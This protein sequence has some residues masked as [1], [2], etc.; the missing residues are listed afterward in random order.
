MTTLL[1]LL[2]KSSNLLKE[3]NIPFALSGGILADYY[4]KDPRATDD[5]DLLVAMSEQE[6]AIGESILKALGFTPTIATEAM[7]RGDTRFKRKTKKSKP[8]IISGRK[9]GTPYGLDFL[10]LTLP[11]GTAALERSLKNCLD[12]GCGK[13]PCLTV[14]DMIISKLFAIKNNSSRVYLKSDIPDISLMILNNTIDLEYLALNMTELELVFPKGLEKE[15][16]HIL[17]RISRRNRK[18]YKNLEF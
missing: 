16:H 5:I 2:E 18:K 7:L 8:Q 4:R 10:L 11:W 17:S 14:E 1:R 12:F 15:V 13:L 9:E 3:R 6:I